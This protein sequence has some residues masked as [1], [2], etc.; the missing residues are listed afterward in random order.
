M[1]GAWS[2]PMDNEFRERTYPL[3]LGALTV[4]VLAGVAGLGMTKESRADVN[5]TASIVPSGLRCEY[6]ANPLSIGT[7]A[8]RLSWVFD[9]V[10]VR[11]RGLRQTA[12]EVVAAASRE[13]L[14]APSKA[15]WRTGK[16]TS[17][18]SLNI[19]YSGVPLRSRQE[20]WWRVRVWDQDDAVSEWS[21][22][23][24][25][26]I[27]LV[28]RNDWQAEWVG[29]DYP[30]KRSPRI[31]GYHSAWANRSNTKSSVTI[32]LGTSNR[33]DKVRLHPTNIRP[34]WP[35]PIHL[36]PVRFRV[37]VSDTADF[38]QY[39]T[40]VDKTDANVPLPLG[41]WLGFVVDTPVPM[42]AII[43]PVEAR[44]VRLVVTKLAK[45]SKGKYGFALAEFELLSQDKPVSHNAD[46]VSANAL[47]GEGWAKESLTDGNT[48]PLYGLLEEAML[49]PMV[50]REFELKKPIRRAIAYASALGLYELHLNGRKIGEQ[51]LAPEWT[52]YDKRMSYQTFDVTDALTEGPNVAA[53]F[54]APGW[55]AG[56]IGI[57]PP[58]T[59]AYGERPAFLLQLEV[60]YEDGTVETVVTDAAWKGSGDGPIT[61]VDFF[62]GTRYD[63]RREVPG[64][65]Q[66]GFNDA[67]WPY[68]QLA[69]ERAGRLVPQYSDPVR[70]T[71][72]LKPV[73]ITEPRPGVYVF[74]LGPIL[75]T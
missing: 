22:P 64:W 75:F 17:D 67:A 18:E 26:R 14:E 33:F 8:P 7:A 50:R 21:D 13:V 73:E 68:V 34:F 63:A 32:D 49:A 47:A 71:Q 27:G 29:V 46:I 45:Q 6:Q 52:D 11:R 66:P 44:Y 55:F 36:F 38:R 39:K 56:Q 43:S 37:D 20:C 41:L 25:F 12:Y 61:N 74:D 62:A 16:V 72:E 5:T 28:S 48:A 54:I 30:F 2:L 60:T 4:A 15:L 59:Q 10:D 31:L 23:A 42:E 40:V 51:V 65:D 1:S 19:V 9:A 70:I 24:S 35:D 53:A 58:T 57:Q 69:G 3:R